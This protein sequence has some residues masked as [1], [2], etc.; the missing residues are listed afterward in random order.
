MSLAAR[1]APLRQARVPTFQGSRSRQ[2]HDG[3]FTANIRSMGKHKSGDQVRAKVHSPLDPHLKS[4]ALEGFGNLGSKKLKPPASTFRGKQSQSGDASKVKR[5]LEGV[6]QAASGRVPDGLGAADERSFGVGRA[7]DGSAVK[8][9]VP[10]D[11]TRDVLVGSSLQRSPLEL[12]P[13]IAAPS[14]ATLAS[15]VALAQESVEQARACNAQLEQALVELQERD[16]RIVRAIG[17]LSVRLD[18]LTA[19][20]TAHAQPTSSRSEQAVQ[21]SLDVPDGVDERKA[22]ARVAKLIGTAARSSSAV[23]PTTPVVTVYRVASSGEV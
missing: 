3:S 19:S 13:V 15:L 16:A 10:K 12:A 22:V 21:I 7:K 11:V 14:P 8:V 17:K 1:V 6:I 9:F 18:R 5:S 20:G 4:S 23:S 2:L